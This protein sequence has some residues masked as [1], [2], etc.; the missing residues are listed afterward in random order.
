MPT[1]GPFPP[2]LCL[3]DRRTN[4]I[5][6]K[7]NEIAALQ[8]RLEVSGREV[9]LLQNELDNK[10]KNMSDRTLEMGQVGRRGAAH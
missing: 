9:L 6:N 2:F 1:G 10:I 3:T 8:K 5:L 7:N 4:E